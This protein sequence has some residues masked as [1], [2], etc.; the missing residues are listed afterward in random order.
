MFGRKPSSDTKGAA[1]VIDDPSSEPEQLWAPAPES[2][3]TRKSIEQLLL[4]RGQINEDQLTQAKHVQSQTPGKSIPQILITMSAATE[5]QVLSA[6]AE[7]LGLAFEVPEKSAVDEKAFALLPA[8][9]IRKNFCLP[10]RF[11]GET[12]LVG[13]SDPNNVFLIDEL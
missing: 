4:E 6:M 7:Q 11:E 1:A 5:G 10:L 13:M 3:K 12:L 8:D 2:G 9:Y